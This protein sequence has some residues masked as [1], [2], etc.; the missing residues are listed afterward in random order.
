[1][2]CLAEGSSNRFSLVA[3]RHFQKM[4]NISLSLSAYHST[5]Y[6]REM[7][8]TLNLIVFHWEGQQE[9]L[10]VTTADTVS[11]MRDEREQG[12]EG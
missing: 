12:K 8:P 6:Q 7:T 4:F 3:L 9:S 10:E 11:K 1:M 2:I 5:H